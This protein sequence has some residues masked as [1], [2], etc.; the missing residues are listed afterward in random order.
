MK[1]LSFFKLFCITSVLSVINEYSLASHI[2][3]IKEINSSAKEE[4]ENF[5]HNSSEILSQIILSAKTGP[6]YRQNDKNKTLINESVTNYFGPEIEI[7]SEK[8][9]INATNSPSLRDRFGLKFISKENDILNGIEKETSLAEANKAEEINI[10]DI[11]NSSSYSDTQLENQLFISF[12]QEPNLYIEATTPPE[13]KYVLIENTTTENESSNYKEFRFPRRNSRLFTRRITKN[14]P[15]Y[16]S[17]I[18]PFTP[19]KSRETENREASQG[20]VSFP[21]ILKLNPE[22]I[23]E[24][25]LNE[26]ETMDSGVE[27][28][29]FKNN[30]NLIEGFEYLRLKSE[31]TS[32]QNGNSISEFKFTSTSFI[33]KAPKKPTK[34]EK[35]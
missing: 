6:I 35:K 20:A 25:K 4:P 23:T 30:I 5:I 12:N 24:N 9:A 14:Y 7:T 19:I 29:V 33:S 2:G 16:Y 18:N 1:P 8:N 10:S 17:G 28:K 27:M 32:F 15:Y 22:Y 26:R 11:Y 34:T 13:S 31:Q 21:V 3:L